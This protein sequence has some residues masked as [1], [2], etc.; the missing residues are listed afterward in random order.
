MFGFISD[1]LSMLLI[2]LSFLPAPILSF[3]TLA[4]SVFALFVCGKFLKWLW[5]ILPI[6]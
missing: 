4:T 3:L 1:F 2:P 5:D 6:A